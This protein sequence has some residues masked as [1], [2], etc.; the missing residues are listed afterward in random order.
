MDKKD[1]IEDTQCAA[2]D[3]VTRDL[4]E[5]GEET[6]PLNESAEESLVEKEDT[7]EA[8]E[9]TRILSEKED[10]LV[11][12]DEDSN[13]TRSETRI[14]SEED[15]EKIKEAYD[16]EIGI[17][18]ADQEIGNEGSEEEYLENVEDDDS[19]VA[20][21]L[22]ALGNVAFSLF[23]ILLIAVIGL[24]ALSF[25]KGEDVEVFGKKVFI[26]G[27]DS[28]AP[29]LK[30]NDAIIVEDL[31]SKSINQG[32]LIVYRNTD[33]KAITA[34]VNNVLEDDNFEIKKDINSKD[35]IIIDGVAIVG[36]AETSIANLGD[37]VDFISNP[38]SLL[39]T[40]FV[41]III[42]VIV[43]FVSNKPR[44]KIQA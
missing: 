13:D 37:F 34:W 15:Q 35:S 19:L 3:Q 22:A 11:E 39:I 33:G 31:P 9:E 10:D 6:E 4:E 41:G 21:I 1:K 8:Q 29:M 38:I 20:T 36:R 2:Q 23:L 12:P 30:E 5:V 18:K 14:I 25:A 27:E 44:K 40:L 16:Q 7:E 17:E 42:Y 24:N 28:M 43:W 26:V 32:D